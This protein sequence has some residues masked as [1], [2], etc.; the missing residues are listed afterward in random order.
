MDAK[1]LRN[2]KFSKKVGKKN[3]GGYEEG[4]D[5]RVVTA[6]DFFGAENPA[7]MLLNTHQ[8]SF[9][10]E[11]QCEE[12]AAHELTTPMIRE[13]CKDLRVLGKGDLAQLMKWR[14]K[15]LRA[16][17]AERPKSIRPAKPEET[18]EDKRDRELNAA[19]ERTTR[20]ERAAVKRKS[21]KAKKEA[22]RAKASLGTFASEQNEPD[23]FQA[24]DLG[25]TALE[26]APMPDLTE[27]SESEEE[28]AG[29]EPILS[30]D[31]RLERMEREMQEGYVHDK[32]R[33]RERKRSA[34]QAAERRKKETRREKMSR[35]WAEEMADF[36]REIDAKAAREA[37]AGDISDDG[38][39]DED[40]DDEEDNPF[41]PA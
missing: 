25:F 1:F 14:F 5:F 13:L 29:V 6:A 21:E 30:D 15:I 10:N 16:R 24:R 36:D 7:A 23:L 28:D 12:I 20:E 34:A 19:L 27:E 8:I 3:R 11:H 4:D 2:L 9:P 41:A 26:D 40:D 18:E 37:E 22:L 17:D 38:D 33:E 32:E 35:E 39:D 31:E